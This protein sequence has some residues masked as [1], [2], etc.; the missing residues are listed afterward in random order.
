[1]EQGLRLWNEGRVRAFWWAL[2]LL[3]LNVFDG[4]FTTYFLERGVAS[5]ANPLMRLAYERSP[6]A[7]FAWKWGLVLS[8]VALLWWS[9]E[10]K[11]ARLTLVGAVGLYAGIV[12]R[13][14][15]ML[16]NVIER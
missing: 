4:A 13:H 7:F 12:A 5:E 11:A 10:A 16:A 15:F 3:G 6:L 14:V 9:R 2:A 8:G 1:M